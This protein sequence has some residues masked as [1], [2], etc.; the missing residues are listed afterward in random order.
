MVVKCGAE[1]GQKRAYLLAHLATDVGE[2]LLSVEAH[3]FY[4]AVT[5]HLGDLGVLLTVRPEHELALVVLVLVLATAPVLAA[6][7]LVLQCV[8]SVPVTHRRR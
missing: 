7:S 3:G 6:L 8:S 1:G 4:A 2:A 5:E